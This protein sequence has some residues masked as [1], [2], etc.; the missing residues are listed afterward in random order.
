[1]NGPKDERFAKHFSK[2][3]NQHGALLRKGARMVINKKAQGPIP[4]LPTA[5]MIQP[6]IAT[7]GTGADARGM[8]SAS[9]GTTAITP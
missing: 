3:P 2:R 7:F 1:M 8:E 5:E 4:A 6:T 9:Q